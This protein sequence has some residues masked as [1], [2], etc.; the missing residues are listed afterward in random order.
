MLIDSKKKIILDA[1][2]GG[3]SGVKAA[4]GR[5]EG[6]QRGEGVEVSGNS[7]VDD[8]FDYFGNEIEIGYGTVAG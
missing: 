3:F 7:I 1:E 6:R 5:L 2:E 4:V 8:T